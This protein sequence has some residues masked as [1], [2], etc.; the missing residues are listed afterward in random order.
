VGI[1]DRAGKRIVISRAPLVCPALGGFGIRLSTSASEKGLPPL[2]WTNGTL[3]FRDRTTGQCAGV[4]SPALAAA[5]GV[6]QVVPVASPVSWKP[7][8][9]SRSRRLHPIRIKP[10]PLRSR[11]LTALVS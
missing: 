1:P 3:Y 9:R 8:S 4:H 10:S 11:P 5:P 2:D 7:S 6:Y